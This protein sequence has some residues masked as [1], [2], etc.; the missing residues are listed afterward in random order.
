VEQVLNE[1]RGQNREWKRDTNSKLIDTQ[2]TL[3]AM[4]GL[5]QS[6][7]LG[8]Q[9]KLVDLQKQMVGESAVKRVVENVTRLE[10]EMQKVQGQVA[11]S[12][13]HLHTIK[14]YI[15]EK[16]STIKQ[17]ATGLKDVEKAMAELEERLVRRMEVGDG[18]KSLRRGRK[19]AREEVPRA[20]FR[21]ILVNPF[22]DI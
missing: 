18:D 20:A 9:T 7:T 5:V 19:T 15:T 14:G 11:K 12:R 2:D 1:D 16:S 21:D 17:L 6:Q 13:Q 22:D 10:G 3:R 4:Q 8:L